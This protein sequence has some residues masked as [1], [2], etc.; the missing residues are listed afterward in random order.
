MLASPFG[1]DQ[2]KPEAKPIV[3]KGDQKKPE[4]NT[5]CRIKDVDVRTSFV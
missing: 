2:K 1:G 4:A 3:Q 5:A